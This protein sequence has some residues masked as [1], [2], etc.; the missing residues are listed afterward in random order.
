MLRLDE[1]ASTECFAAVVE[2]VTQADEAELTAGV[3]GLVPALEGVAIG[4]GGLLAGL[5]AG[6]IEAGAD[7]RPVL[8]AL[9]A[10]VADGLE[11]AA[12][13][14]AL[15]EMAGEG[16][17]NDEVEALTQAR[18]TINGW[19]PG[20]LVPLQQKRARLALPQRD[21]LT[22]AT[23]AV[24]GPIEDAAW[25]LGLLLVLDDEQIVVVHRE[26]GRAYEVTIAGVGDNFQLHTLLAAVLV[27]DPD[28]GYLPG[29]SPPP[30]WV[31]AAATGEM[32]PPGG[33]TGQFQLVDAAG[34]DVSQGRPADLP[35]VAERRVVVLDRPAVRRT[36]NVGRVFPLMSPEIN[37]DRALPADEAARWLELIRPQS[38]T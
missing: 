3:A 11:Q 15:A 19:L 38:P 6:L 12:V 35:P 30:E 33:I 14:E 13:Y 36:W 16:L 4:N 28:D 5:V 20:L 24:V 1:R 21:R 25:L 22:S 2:R 37:V 32:A 23:A 29:E 17:D 8:P 9:V 27:G 7:P 34:T 31:A 18:F 26:T 10:R